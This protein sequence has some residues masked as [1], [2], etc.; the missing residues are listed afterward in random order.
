MFLV[1]WLVI[2]RRITQATLALCMT[3]LLVGCGGSTGNQE[4]SE[5]GETSQ[6]DETG[7]TGE[8][9]LPIITSFGAS[10]DTLPGEGGEVTLSWS[11]IG[12]TELSIDP[13][14]GLVTGD[15]V[16][17]NVAVT[18]VFTLTASNE[19]GS[20]TAT[21]AVSVGQNP[22][23]S[24]GRRVDMI[25]PTGGE[26]FIAPASLRLVASGRDPNV[27]TNDPGPGHGGNA[28]KVQF[29]VDDELVLEIDGLA[30]EYWI[31]KGFVADVPAGQHLVWARAIY[32][33]PDLVL[34]SL[35]VI[36]DVLEPPDYAQTIELDA[37][38]MLSGDTGYT[39]SGTADARI[40]LNG[41][42]HSIRSSDGASGPLTLE[43]VDVFDLGDRNDTSSAAIDVT[44]SG[45]VTITR[46]NFD[47]SNPVR[48]SANGSTATIRDNVFRSNMRMPIGQYPDPSFADGPSYPVAEFDGSGGGARIFAGNN[49]GASYVAFSGGGWAIGGDPA[50]DGNVFIGPRVGVSIQG[51]AVV[52]GNYS[53]HVYYGGWSQG[54]NFELGGGE[55]LAEHNVIIGSSW[56]VRGVAG[57]FRYNLVMEAGH[58]WLWADSSD[59]SIHHN[60]FIGGEADVGGIYVLY[61]PQNV[62]IFNNTIDGQDVIGR[63]VQLDDGVVSFTSN[64]LYR[65]P[66]PGVSIAGGTLT[67]D[68][69]AFFD[70]AQSYS[71]GA[72]PSN[73]ITGVDPSLTEPV[74]GAP[75]DLDE[76]GVWKRTLTVPTIL[77]V[78]R[79]RYSP[80]AGSPVIDAGDPAGG[81]GND[82]GAV[83]AG[84]PNVDDRFGV[85]D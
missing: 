26:S 61:A 35:P 4:T 45:P 7:E 57:E 24:G 63:A 21:T 46:S 43:F 5:S 30:A 59:S 71:D 22:P 73:D 34:D 16:T 14:V 68:Y 72:S 74:E 49:V 41:N 3:A 56:P 42:G 6:P 1:G 85:F 20:A 67:A 29:F 28:S 58:Q 25:A 2:R 50:A 84:E 52:R 19:H 36:V 66:S 38:V 18:T 65:V 81:S 10:P 23:A 27:F 64:L 12:A 13:S 15:E 82:I 83:G 79:M 80:Q 53:H 39:L 48:V 40:R 62:G 47:G 37:D 17:T 75:F 69:N 55:V 76:V 31:F 70:P 33:D 32:V 8:D 51:D 54:A 9:G 78:Y 60:V 77:G 11:V 44:T